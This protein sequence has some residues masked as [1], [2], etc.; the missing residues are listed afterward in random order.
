MTTQIEEKSRY[1]GP[2]FLDRGFRPFFFGAAVFAAV[3]VPIWVSVLAL[4]LEIPSPLSPRDWHIHEMIFGYVA[5]V[6]AGFLLTAVPNWTGRLPVAGRPL[7]GLFAVWV[8]GRLMM[9]VSGLSDSPKVP[10]IAA[11][12]DAAFLVLLAGVAWREVAAGRNIRNLPICGLVL[13]LAG[14]NIGFHIAALD[15][16]DTG[17]FQRLALAVI[18]ALITLVGG[19]IVPSFSRNWMVKAG[20]EVLPAPFDRVDKAAMAISGAALL[21]WVALPETIVGAVL[22]GLGA[23]AL[24]IR[25]SRWRGWT[26]AGDHLVLIL[27]VG[28]AWLPVWFGL[29]AVHGIRP[30]IID[31]S[32][33][34]HALTAGAAGTMTIAVMTR[35]SL[36]HSGRSLV[37]DRLTSIV[38]A[39]IVAGASTRVA[40]GFLPLDYFPALT[41]A[42]LLW[43]A[44]FA[45]FA[46]GYGPMLLGLANRR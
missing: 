43:S 21:C 44:G 22:F 16:R 8:A 4:G 25:L 5:A 3:A 17:L 30:D 39:L 1:R 7:A 15:G 9:A 10:L 24:A 34:M 11:T 42:G 20:M 6:I 19:R 41:A 38:Y 33:A 45:L 14:A 28:Y 36:G 32:T 26:T 46:V 35:A 12:V 13:L 27:H 29:M 18:A 31:S 2:V 37:A 23:V 40:A